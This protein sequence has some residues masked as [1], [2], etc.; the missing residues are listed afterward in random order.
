MIIKD[1]VTAKERLNFKR[2]TKW[3]CNAIATNMSARTLQ[4][5]CTIMTG[6][7]QKIIVARP[8]QSLVTQNKLIAG[9]V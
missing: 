1:Y 9:V 8:V 3:K 6:R 2:I 4:T 5:I 7:S